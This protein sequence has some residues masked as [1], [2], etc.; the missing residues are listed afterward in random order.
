[1]TLPA[2]VEALARIAIFI[3]MT[4][5]TRLRLPKSRPH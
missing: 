1:M 4:H 3:G 2:F 5:R